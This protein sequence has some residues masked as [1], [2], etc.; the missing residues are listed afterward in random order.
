MQAAKGTESV[1]LSR[2]LAW[3]QLSFPPHLSTDV[4][5]PSTELLCWLEGLSEKQPEHPLLL[6]TAPISWKSRLCQSRCLNQR[7]LDERE[8]LTQIK[9]TGSATAH[10]PLQRLS[11][12][13]SDREAAHRAPQHGNT[14]RQLRTPLGQL[15][16]P[17]RG[18]LST[19]SGQTSVPLRLNG[20]CHR[21]T[22][23]RQRDRWGCVSQS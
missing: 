11:L 13:P 15:R 5:G 2:S 6:I 12:V 18:L 4:S 21:V 3:K 23:S 10:L 8:S 14:P 17:P 22:H 19:K 16:I 20:P 9:V 7:A 1:W